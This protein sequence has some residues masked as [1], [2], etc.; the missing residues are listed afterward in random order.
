MGMFGLWIINRKA[1]VDIT[2]TGNQVRELYLMR[3]CTEVPYIW[4]SSTGS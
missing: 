3:L 4:I 1:N 2:I